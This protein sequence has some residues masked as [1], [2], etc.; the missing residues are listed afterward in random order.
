MSTPQRSTTAP[1]AC[2]ACASRDDLKL[3][4]IAQRKLTPGMELSPGWIIGAIR[5]SASG[6]TIYLTMANRDFTENSSASSNCAVRIGADGRPVIHD[7][8]AE[9]GAAA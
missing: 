9:H 1:A 2:G 7:L 5:F 6:K 3:A 4:W 8:A